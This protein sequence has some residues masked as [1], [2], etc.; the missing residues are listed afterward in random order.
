[1]VPTRT[2]GNRVSAPAYTAI[3]SP[4][5]TTPSTTSHHQP[6]RGEPHAA[7]AATGARNTDATSNWTKAVRT[8]PYT[9]ATGLLTR[10]SIAN[11]AAAPA[12]NHKPAVVV[13][14][15]PVGRASTANPAA[16]TRSANA[17][18]RSMRSPSTAGA[19]TATST[20]ATY[21]MKITVATTMC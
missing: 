16:A 19:S 3:A 5:C 21:T 4:V 14:V 2:A 20:G 17:L 1:M 18:C 7:R 9:A 15:V 6:T 13:W 12:D 10:T 11:V 8:P